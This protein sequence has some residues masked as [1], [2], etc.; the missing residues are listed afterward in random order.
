MFINQKT[1]IAIF[2]SIGALIAGSAITFLYVDSENSNR[3]ICEEYQL[4]YE[5]G[6]CVNEDE[7][8]ELEKSYYFILGNT[9]NS[10]VIN[11]T[12]ITNE[13]ENFGEELRK[14]ILSSKN[15]KIKFFSAS[16][17][18]KA[19]FSSSIKREGVNQQKN[20]IDSIS[21]KL[22]KEIV[23]PSSEDG[24][25]YLEAILNIDESIKNRKNTELIVVGSGL[26]DTGLLNFAK[27]D[28]LHFGNSSE[29]TLNSI[30]SYLE[31]LNFFKDH[32]LKGLNIRWFNIGETVAPQTPLSDPEKSLV[33]KIYKTVLEKLGAKVSFSDCAST[34][35]KYNTNYVVL[36][37][38]TNTPPPIKSITAEELG[39]NPNESTFR[40]EEKTAKV[41]EDSIHQAKSTTGK[42]IITGYIAEGGT[43]EV[44]KTSTLP[45]DRAEAVKSILANNGIDESR[46]VAVNGGIAEGPE[47]TEE[48]MKLKRKV[49]IEYK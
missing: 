27:D 48:E 19:I 2:A 18:N 33:K 12:F 16:P 29:E 6:I 42:I 11:S 14:S 7:D 32:N 22:A 23:K 34:T 43:G 35:D 17:S 5:N 40:D 36:V 37:T 41:L 8:E 13:E 24:A 26:S 39:F 47:T 31:N 9:A 25:A 21:R 28:L 49:T 38:K 10:P 30:T 20:A 3:K 15:A 4:V 46:L 1:K 44:A 45:L